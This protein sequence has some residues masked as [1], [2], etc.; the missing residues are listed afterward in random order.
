M[1]ATVPVWASLQKLRVAGL[2][3]RVLTSLVVDL[4]VDTRAC[5]APLVLRRVY[6]SEP[7]AKLAA[8][9]ALLGDSK[10]GF[11]IIPPALPRA[12]LSAD[13]DARAGWSAPQQAWFQQLASHTRESGELVREPGATHEQRGAALTT[14]F[15]L[16]ASDRLKQLW[17]QQELTA[18]WADL[19]CLPSAI[20]QDR[21]REVQQTIGADR[22]KRV[23]TEHSYRVRLCCPTAE[24]T[25]IV[26]GCIANYALLPRE[27]PETAKRLR[28]ILAGSSAGLPQLPADTSTSETDSSDGDGE[29][30]TYHSSRRA[31]T[32]QRR[33]A[34]S[35][36][37]QL[38]AFAAKELDTARCRADSARPLLQ[39]ASRVTV[40]SWQ[41][42][43]VECFVSNWQSVGCRDQFDLH[44][45]AF[46]RVVTAVPELQD[47][48]AVRWHLRDHVG[49]TLVSL[50]VRDD[51]CARLPKLNVILRQLPDLQHAAL[52]VVCD[53]HPRR[54]RG[55]RSVPGE[56]RR[57][58][59]TPEDAPSVPRPS[60]S[61][62]ASSRLVPG[63]STVPSWAA[64]LSAARPVPPPTA[65]RPAPPLPLDHR[66]RKEQRLE[67]STTA[68]APLPPSTTAQPAARKALPAAW[69]ARVAA[70]EARLSGI[71]ALCDSLRDVPRLL[72]SIQQKLDLQ[73]GSPPPSSL[74][75]PLPRRPP[76]PA[77]E[78][79]PTVREASSS[80]TSP[81]SPASAALASTVDELS[82]RMDAQGSLLD[83][84]G[85]QIGEL[86]RGIQE[87]ARLG[88]GL[89]Q[90]AAMAPVA[91]Q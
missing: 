70:L 50:F 41:H 9:A 2:D 30:Q 91:R 31:A 84:L 66:P 63:A 34:A 68:P 74:P 12:L 87:I 67:P 73:L 61:G 35:R 59:L 55:Q 56:R 27:A 80:S 28:A 8:V 75:S 19:L 47:A 45:P 25:Y 69:E 37:K 5:P 23:V 81:A 36:A 71:Q 24:V 46:Q 4:D 49:G 38:A 10:E 18:A 21:A 3:P 20:L 17:P 77:P 62:V 53:A 32:Q 48:A 54:T 14:L 43:F 6:S 65:R 86:T 22:A 16:I 11:A 57:Y 89:P 40:R 64:V 85:D 13:A 51:L 39:L 7:T 88:G 1:G 79:V 82:R 72:A 83:R 33:R 90:S 44:D 52:K 58:V 26:A 15:A 42:H 76:A 29:W 60:P 78:G